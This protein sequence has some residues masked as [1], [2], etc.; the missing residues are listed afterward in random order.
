M[1]RRTTDVV[2]AVHRWSALAKSVSCTAAVPDPNPAGHALSGAGSRDSAVTKR[3]SGQR[4]RVAQTA[5]P[6]NLYCHHSVADNLISVCHQKLCPGAIY[7]S[8][9]AH[10]RLSAGSYGWTH[11]D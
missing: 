11:L 3:W 8:K 9:A 6:A 10:Q 5:G 2:L 7:R 1:S 4:H